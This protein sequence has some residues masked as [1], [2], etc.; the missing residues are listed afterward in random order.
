MLTLFAFCC[1]DHDY[2][3][4]PGLVKFDSNDTRREVVIMASIDKFLELNETFEL[5][6]LIDSDAQG[7]GITKSNSSVA[8][9]T[10]L[11]NDS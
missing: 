4:I 10:I 9:I 1:V 6:F 11:N 7:R 5:H 8:T 3:I 2:T